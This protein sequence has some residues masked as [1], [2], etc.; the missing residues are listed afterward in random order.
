MRARALELPA[1]PPPQEFVRDAETS[2]RV[3]SRTPDAATTD[4]AA[5]GLPAPVIRRPGQV[6]L[7]APRTDDV[8][9]RRRQRRAGGE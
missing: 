4:G 3:S 7:P 8:I 2:V 9:T 6:A 5:E 1:A